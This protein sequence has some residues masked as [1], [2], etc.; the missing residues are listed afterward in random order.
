MRHGLDVTIAPSP[1][2]GLMTP[3]REYPELPRIGIGGVVIRD[4]SALLIRRG[5]EP[6]KG[7][8]SI[9][10]GMLEVGETLVEGVV[11]ELLEETGLSVRVIELIEVFERIFYPRYNGPTAPV[12]PNDAIQVK[13][14]KPGP[15]YHFV[16][17][18]YL[19]EALDGV[20]RAGGDV[21][22]VAFAAEED[23]GRFLLTPAAT[24]IVKKA[25]AMGRERSE[26]IR[27][28]PK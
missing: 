22:D 16:I 24:R 28:K 19:C 13:T 1:L 3:K 4:G 17:V 18:D 14:G 26:G 2:V 15:L 25:F 12:P 8:W 11:R 6:L 23:L 7:E 10:G 27:D 21:T 5:A 20:P 9:P